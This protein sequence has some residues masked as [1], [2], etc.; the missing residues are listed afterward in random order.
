MIILR[1]ENNL[2]G[3]VSDWVRV[4]DILVFAGFSLESSGGSQSSSM[5]SLE[6]SVWEDILDQN[7]FILFMKPYQWYA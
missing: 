5:M 7:I 3:G 4:E 2:G 6:D 1:N